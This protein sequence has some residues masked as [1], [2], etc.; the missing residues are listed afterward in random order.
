M[1]QEPRRQL[2]LKAGV[3]PGP[4]TFLAGKLK[5]TEAV[6]T[7]CVPR[8]RKSS[9]EEGGRLTWEIPK[10]TQ[11]DGISSLHLVEDYGRSPFSSEDKGWA[12][13][14]REREDLEERETSQ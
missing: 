3:G 14:C 10:S 1:L 9:R 2:N 13:N 7:S 4:S 12:E 8:A 11:K 5:P 6:H